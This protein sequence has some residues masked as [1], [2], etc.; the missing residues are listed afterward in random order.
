MTCPEKLRGLM[1]LWL[2]IYQIEDIETPGKLFNFVIIINKLIYQAFVVSNCIV[3][4]KRLDPC[5]RPYWELEARQH[6]IV[7]KNVSLIPGL[8]NIPEFWKFESP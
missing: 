2:D 5:I 7:S 4:R 1:S 8:K 6:A 3:S